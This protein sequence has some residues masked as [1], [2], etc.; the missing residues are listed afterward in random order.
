[1]KCTLFV[2]KRKLSNLQKYSFFV[3]VWYASDHFVVY[4][5]SGITVFNK[6][7]VATNLRGLAVNIQLFTYYLYIICIVPKAGYTHIVEA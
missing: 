3:R 1:M 6:P 7:P 2:D 4:K 5:S